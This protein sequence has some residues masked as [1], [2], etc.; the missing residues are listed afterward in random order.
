MTN[1]LLQ[2]ALLAVGGLQ[3]L[4]MVIDG[5]H[6]IRTGSYIGGQVG[7]WAVIVRAAGLNVY[8][9]GPFFLA[10]GSLWLLGCVLLLV[11]PR[12]GLILLT[13][14]ASI[15]LL[16]ALFGTVL[17]I[18]ALAMVVVCRRTLRKVQAEERSAP[19]TQAT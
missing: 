6:V 17:S 5:F 11:R 2:Y 18:I 12:N 19:R 8:R 3:G 4:F 15:S 9:M 16:Y 13:M 1:R 14:T 7:P 10:L